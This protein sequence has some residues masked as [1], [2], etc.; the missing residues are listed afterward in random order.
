MLITNLVCDRD[1]IDNTNE[2]WAWMSH[3]GSFSRSAVNYNAGCKTPMTNIIMS[4]LVLLVLAVATPLFHN[5]PNCIL[6]SIIINAVLGLFDYNAM[7]KIW[8][9][10]MADFIIMVCAFLGVVFG[11]IE[12]GLLIAVCI[13]LCFDSGTIA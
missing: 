10:D 11:S 4:I 1:G 7:Y 5:T 2:G 3:V 6:A 13:V 8:R 9:V 12:V